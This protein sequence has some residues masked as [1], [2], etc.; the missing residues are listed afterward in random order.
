MTLFLLNFYHTIASTDI[1]IYIYI[2]IYII[3]QFLFN[4]INLVLPLECNDVELVFA[5]H[6][7][8]NVA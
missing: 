2:Y 8:L 4:A 1:Y 6:I 5:R 3:S 7:F